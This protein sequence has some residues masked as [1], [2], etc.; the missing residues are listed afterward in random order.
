MKQAFPIQL[1]RFGRSYQRIKFT[2][3]NKSTLYIRHVAFN[4]Y[5]R[6]ILYPSIYASIYMDYYPLDQCVCAFVC[7]VFLCVCR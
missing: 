3:F 6:T 2:V 4:A 7:H 1:V 5:A